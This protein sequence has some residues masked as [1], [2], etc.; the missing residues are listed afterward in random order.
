L[1]KSIMAILT[2]INSNLSGSAGNW[3][4]SRQGNVTIAKQKVSKKKVPVRTYEQ[5]LRR[6]QWP[7]LVNFYRC[8]EG[9]LHP[10]F[11]RRPSCVSDFNEFISA[12]IGVVPVYL[13][14]DQARQ[15]GAVVAPYQVTRGSLPSVSL[16]ETMAGSSNVFI[17]NIALGSLGLDATT[18]VKAFSDAVVAANP[19]F[20]N[21]DQITCFIARQTVNSENQTPYVHIDA[22]ELTLDQADGS[23]KVWDVVTAAGFTAHDG[24]LGMAQPVN[25]GVAY[26]HSRKQQGRTLVST[27]RMECSNSQLATFQTAAQRSE[28]IVSYGGVLRAD[29][30]TPND[31]NVAATTNP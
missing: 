6:V 14:R 24:F 28:A 15:G 31:E 3:T 4:Y 7:N 2:G 5:M 8:F 11:E 12:N 22:Y 13:T 1:N 20:E 18:T 21:G 23:T 25:G 30:L 10:S 27:Q 29:Y 17:S 9:N 19:D 16:D 26:I